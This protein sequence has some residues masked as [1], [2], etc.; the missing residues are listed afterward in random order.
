MEMKESFQS[1]QITN[2]ALLALMVGVAAPVPESTQTQRKVNQDA[3]KE[4]LKAR[5]PHC[6]I[7][8]KNNT[9]LKCMVLDHALSPDVVT[10]GHIIG[11]TNSQSF[12]AVGL[13]YST[14]R[15]HERN[16][17]LIHKHI[18]VKYGHQLVVSLLFVLFNRHFVITFC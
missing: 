7:V 5:Y 18:D 11:L 12:P 10:A 3:F 1:M 9:L 13:N 17:L 16:G 4:A 8:R 14:H 2:N 15:Y 6:V